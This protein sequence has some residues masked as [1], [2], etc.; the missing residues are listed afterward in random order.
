MTLSNKDIDSLVKMKILIENNKELLFGVNTE[1]KKADFVDFI[2]V[3]E[4]IKKDKKY[5]NDFSNK[6][7]KRKRLVKKLSYARQNNNI[8]DIEKYN[9]LIDELDKKN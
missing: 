3:I 8:E 2:N 1:I 9:K 5:V 7:N 4:K 6:L